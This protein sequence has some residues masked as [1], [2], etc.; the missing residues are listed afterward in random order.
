MRLT[1]FAL[2]MA[3][4]VLVL[5]ALVSSASA[6]RLSSTTQI[7][8]ASWARLNFRGGLGTVECEVILNGTF[9]SRTIAKVANSLIGFFTAA[10][11]TRCARG[12]ATALRETLPWH[13]QYSS[14]SGTL[15]VISSHSIR[16]IGESFRVS[17]PVFGVNCLYRT[18]TTEPSFE[19]YNRNTSTGATT[20]VTSSGTIRCGEGGI[21]LEGT[22][23]SITAHTVT[24]I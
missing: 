22:S 7:I 13:L 5:A 20:S 12:N 11:V 23:S 24:L 6:G 19:T 21:R 18:S 2:A 15:P 3:G 10:N 16:I 14:F 8:N 4:A 17:E 9:H 1:K